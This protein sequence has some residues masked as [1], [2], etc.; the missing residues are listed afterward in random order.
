MMDLSD[1]TWTQLWL[2]DEFACE[3]E[4]WILEIKQN[5]SDAN[6]EVLAT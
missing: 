4:T 2:A 6:T 5:T 1:M 3:V